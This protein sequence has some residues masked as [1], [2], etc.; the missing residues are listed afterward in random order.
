[1][2]GGT[3]SS[4]SPERD[5]I[6]LTSGWYVGHVYLF[7]A[8]SLAVSIFYLVLKKRDKSFNFKG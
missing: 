2:F 1:M 8:V 6:F 7:R 5:Y 3:N 4:F